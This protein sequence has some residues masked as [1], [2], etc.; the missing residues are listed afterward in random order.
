MAETKITNV[1]VPEVFT[2]YVLEPSIYRNRFLKSGVLAANNTI[3]SLLAGGGKTFNLPFWQDLDD[4]NSSV[5][6]ETVALTVGN[7]T[8]EKQIAV[9][10]QRNRAWGANAMSAILSGDDPMGAIESFVGGYWERDYNKTL[11]SI[12]NGVFADNIANDSSDLV[13]DSGLTVFSSD[14]VIDAQALL[15]E[16]GVVGRGDSTE[17]VG[18]AVHPNTYA[19]MR[20][21]D[22]IDFIPISGQTRPIPFYMGMEVIV[23]RR[24]PTSTNSN[25]TEYTSYMYKAGAL[26]FGQTSRGYEATSTDRDESKGMGIDK[27]YTR[28]VYTI[29]PTGFAFQ[30]SSVAGES[31]TNTELEA[32][33]NWDRVFEK[34]NIGIVA[35]IHGI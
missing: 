6:S 29:H 18:I 1:V 5:P 33:A 12:C 10:L 35:Y 17:Y 24:M 27:L 9:R 20:K 8:A 21:L 23:D 16:N 30:S 4:T 25:G 13:N 15:G 14:G 11:V 3:D 2:K 28:R 31:P 22:V 34:E 7:I 26:Q 32:A 19:K